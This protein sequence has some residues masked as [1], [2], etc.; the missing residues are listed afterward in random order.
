M[1]KKSKTCGVNLGNGETVKGEFELIEAVLCKN[2]FDPTGKKWLPVIP[3]H[4]RQN[5]LP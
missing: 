4:L 5:I 1:K 3:K 2:N